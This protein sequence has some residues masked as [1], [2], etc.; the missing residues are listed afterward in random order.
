[1]FRC[2]GAGQ[3]GQ[4]G[5]GGRN[6]QSALPDDGLG[7]RMGRHA[8]CH[9]IQTGS[10]FIGDLGIPGQNDGQRAGPEALHEHPGL[11]RHHRNHIGQRRQIGD[12]H[13]EGVVIGTAL[14]LENGVH[15]LGVQGIGCQAIDC[16]G[17][18]RHQFSLP[19]QFSRRFDCLA[20]LR[21]GIGFIYHRF[22]D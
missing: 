15:C 10:G 5:R 22:H 19:E 16:F 20:E 17:G 14:G 18:D 11:F 8:H 9:R 6:G 12:M 21:F 3:A 7:H 1:M 13:D 4:I 2:G